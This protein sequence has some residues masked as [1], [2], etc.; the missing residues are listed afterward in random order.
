VNPPLVVLDSMVIVAA[1]VGDPEGASAQA[2]RAVATG[3]VRLAIS[4]EYLS[5]LVRV[6]GYP[7]IEENIERPVRAFE[8]AL[9]LGTMGYM[10]HPRRLD[11]PSLRDYGDAFLFDLAFEASV[12]HIVSSDTAVRD[13]AQDLGFSAI[14]PAQLLHILRRRG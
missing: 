6:F 2:V 10:Y 3:S 14:Y 13:A 12:D 1:V 8:V 5:E 11:W 4:D 7:A 9:D